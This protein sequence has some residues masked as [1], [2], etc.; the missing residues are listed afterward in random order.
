MNILSV[1]AMQ[2]L[3]RI[4]VAVTGRRWG[5]DQSYSTVPIAHFSISADGLDA[6]QDLRDLAALVAEALMGEL[7]HTKR[8]P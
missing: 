4:D 6:R 7:A 2:F 5:K 1:H 8:R 3:D